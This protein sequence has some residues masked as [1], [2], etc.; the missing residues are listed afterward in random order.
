[1]D[2]DQSIVVRM[3]REAMPIIARLARE[4]G[5]PRS[6]IARRLVM[7]AIAHPPKWMRDLM[8]VRS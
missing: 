7:E 4:T 5:V 1:M 6:T 2:E 8:E 3:P